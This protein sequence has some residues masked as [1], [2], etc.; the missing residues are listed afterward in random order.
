MPY[1]HTVV[2][3]WLVI[4]TASNLGAAL[5]LVLRTDIRLTVTYWLR[6]NARSA[7]SAGMTSFQM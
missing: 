2:S 5:P 3:Y 1:Q 4:N 7:W 6:E